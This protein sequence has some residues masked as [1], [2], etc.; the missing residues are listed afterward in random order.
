MPTDPS[1]SNDFFSG[2]AAF[3][4]STFAWLSTVVLG[5]FGGG[6]LHQRIVQL[7]KDSEGLSGLAVQV[8]KIEAKIDILL[9]DRRRQG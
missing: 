1:S 3:L 9:D 5:I 2:F 6:K 7:E 8:A 4:A